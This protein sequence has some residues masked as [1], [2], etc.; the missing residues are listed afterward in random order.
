MAFL[1][2]VDEIKKDYNTGKFI[3]CYKNGI[4]EELSETDLITKLKETPIIN[5]YSENIKAGLEMMERTTQRLEYYLHNVLTKGKLN[6]APQETLK[7]VIITDLLIEDFISSIENSDKKKWNYFAQ[8]IDS[9]IQYFS[10]AKANPLFNRDLIEY[11]IYELSK[12][13]ET[14]NQGTQYKTPK[15]RITA[16]MYAITYILDCKANGWERLRGRKT[17]IENFIRER[18]IKNKP[19][20]APNTVY[21]ELRYLEVNWDNAGLKEAIGKEWK[22][23]VLELS[24]DKPLLESYIDK[25][26]EV[27]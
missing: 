14:T 8:E 23:I 5:E 25:H 2:L 13:R 24:A 26:I 9:L 19:K 10:D 18:Y 7:G 16:K 27:K 6:E 1:D 12:L 15:K 21:K 11:I 20:P 4:E 17:E 3:I 22:S